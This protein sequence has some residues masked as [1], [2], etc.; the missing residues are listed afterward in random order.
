MFGR[1]STETP[2]L[3]MA[4][5]R[6]WTWFRAEAQGIANAFEALARGEADAD[7]ALDGLNARIRRIDASLDAD[8]VRTLDGQCHMT[9]SGNERAIDAVIAAAPLM[10]G[11]RFTPRAVLADPRRVP[12]RLAP[13][14]SLDLLAAP[15]SARHDAY[16]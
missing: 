1:R 6:F 16:A 5:R 2:P 3:S 4:T 11:W 15:I 13:R 14:P 7:A 10:P 9:I 12:F 8:V